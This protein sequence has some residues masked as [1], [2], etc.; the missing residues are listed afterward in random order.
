MHGKT[1][2]PS[3][4]TANRI[5]QCLARHVLKQIAFRSR[6]NGSVNVFVAIEGREY[7]NPRVLIV[8]TNLFDNADTIELGHAQIE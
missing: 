6:L 8:S 5:N 1:G 3:V 7:D 2:L 4:D